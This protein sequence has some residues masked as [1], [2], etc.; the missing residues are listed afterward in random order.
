MIIKI[1][2]CVIVSFSKNSWI[3]PPLRLRIQKLWGSNPR[4]IE[5]S[6]EHL[7]LLYRQG[8]VNDPKCFFLPGFLFTWTF[9][10]ANIFSVEVVEVSI[11]STITKRFTLSCFI[12]KKPL[13][14]WS[15]TITGLFG[16]ITANGFCKKNDKLGFHGRLNFTEFSFTETRNDEG[17]M[18]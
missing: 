2:E 9:L 7:F 15:H 17:E 4:E 5:K 1:T 8:L 14:Q 6:V 3:C 18:H 13:A 12:V 11:A 16:Q 10:P